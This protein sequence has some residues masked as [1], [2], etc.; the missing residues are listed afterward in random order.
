MTTKAPQKPG[1]WLACLPI[2]LTFVVLGVQL[3]YFGNFTPHVPLAIGVAI[4][5]LI[6]WLRGYRWNDMEDGI[7]H[8]VR[9][10]LQ[11]VGILIIVGMIVGIW[12]ASGTVPYLIKLGLSLISPEL[13]LAA[14][15]LICAVVSVSLGTSWGTTGTVGLALMGIGNGFDIPMYW[16]AGAVVSGAFFGDKMSPLSD[17]TNLAPAVTG[18]NLFDH[19]RNMLPT[20]IP[21][22]LIALVIYLVAGFGLIGDQAVNFTRIESIINGLDQNFELSWTLLLPLVVTIGLALKKM[23]ALPTLFAGALL[24]LATAM[25]TQGVGLQQAFEFMFSGYQIDTGVREIDALLNRGG[26]QSMTWVITLMLVALAFGGV[27]ERTGCLE[28]IVEKILGRTNS[29]GAMQS[30]AIATSAMTN[31]V[32]GDPYLSIAL[33]GR[34]YAPAYKAKGY[35]PLN[36]SRACEEGGTLIS[37]LI[38][39]NAGGAVVITALGLGISEGNTENLLYIPLAFACW[40]SPLIGMAY[41][42]LG[43]FSPKASAKEK[44][45]WQREAAELAAEP[46]AVK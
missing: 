19:I 29:F 18:V 23:P 4:T 31:V 24:G 44:E 39:W 9:L 22:M 45:Q 2:A 30:S 21:A 7:M 6:G 33:P 26:I 28:T 13:F 43:W 3:F 37:P 32:G 16:T 5:A 17:T 20:T 15:V 41:A 42:H 35:S 27:L 11:S 40:L 36:L 46:V 25:L 38:P 8:V 34:M 1:F 10:G 12:I 14:S